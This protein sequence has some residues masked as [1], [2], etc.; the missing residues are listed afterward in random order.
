MRVASGIDGLMEATSK[1]RGACAI[2]RSPFGHASERRAKTRAVIRVESV[3]Y[4]KKGD[5]AYIRITSFS[6]KTDAGL[7]KAMENVRNRCR[8]L[9]CDVRAFGFDLG[10]DED[11][12]RQQP[13]QPRDRADAD[14]ARSGY[15]VRDH[16]RE[17]RQQRERREA[18]RRD[19]PGL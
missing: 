1:A 8:D 9:G 7:K 16:E 12:L 14:R 17:D 19:D 4:E 10:F 11:D 13:G 15:H 3:K 5:V 2:D 18:H 6:E